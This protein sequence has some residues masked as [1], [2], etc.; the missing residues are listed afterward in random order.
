MAHQ[1]A[2][3][4]DRLIDQM[5]G[6]EALLLSDNLGELGY[7]LRLRVAA[8][9]GGGAIARRAT[10]QEVKSAYDLRSR[11]VHGDPVKASEVRVAADSMDSYLR[12]CLT[13]LLRDP[14]S[15]AWGD[16]L[17]RLDEQVVR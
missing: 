11:V 12:A 15:I 7:R 1:R 3:H 5:I 6:F 4:A 13:K 9:L 16:W 8:F 2:I 17:K 10:A 14:P